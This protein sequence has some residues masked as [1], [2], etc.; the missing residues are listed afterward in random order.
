[1]RSQKIQHSFCLSLWERP[2]ATGRGVPDGYSANT[3]FAP[4]FM[5]IFS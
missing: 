1:M 3:Y 4:F 2:V 5:I